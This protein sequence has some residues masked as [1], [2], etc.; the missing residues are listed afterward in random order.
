[1]SQPTATTE[2]VAALEPR[3]P[4][5]GTGRPGAAAAVLLLVGG[6]LGIVQLVLPWFSTNGRSTT[7]WQQ[8][9]NTAHPG[10]G[11]GVSAY[12]IIIAAL[13]GIVMLL[14]GLA[15]LARPG[16]GRAVGTVALVA[17]LVE[18]ACMVW[19]LGLGPVTLKDAFGS[20]GIGWYCFLVAGIVGA[21]GAGKARARVGLSFDRL[22][23][24]AIFLGVPLVIFIVFVVSPFVQAIYYSLTSWNGFTPDKP[25]VGIGNYKTLLTDDT[26]RRSVLNSIEL[27][28]V[29]PLVTIILAIAIATMVTVGGPSRGPVRG[30][31]ASSLYRVVSFFP[32]TIPAIVIGLIWANVLDPSAGILNAFLTGIGLSGFTNFAWLG[33]PSSAMPVS[34]FVIIWSFV[35]FYAVFFVAAIKGVS[36]EV[37]E[38]ARLDGAGRFRTATRVTIPLIR[39]SVQTAYIYLGIAALDSFVYMQALNPFGGPNN[40]TLTMSQ[41]LYQTAFKGT[42][43]FG[44]ASAMGV[45]LAVVT[46]LFATVV[47]TVNRLTGGGRAAPTRRRRHG[48]E[49]IAVA[50]Q[51]ATKTGGI[52]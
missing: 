2:R 26:F 12:A 44:L 4:A 11:G 52:V 34:M 45:V 10:F 50:A 27:G 15:V 25:F 23:F 14:A 46:L 7:G 41:D 39:D 19:W 21:F 35:G 20:A 43:Q 29:V 42:N 24:M 33:V 47:F 9:Y 6:V 36:A 40:T 13:A 18:V 30:L 32:Y 8:Y 17:A 37:Y 5:A 16:L 28:I 48:S 49:T 51:P 3:T 38:A 1:M 31:R 22:S